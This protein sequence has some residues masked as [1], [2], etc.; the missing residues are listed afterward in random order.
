MHCYLQLV[1]VL[2]HRMNTQTQERQVWISTPTSGHIKV[3]QR[4]LD[5]I[6]LTYKYLT[7]SIL[8]TFIKHTIP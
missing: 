6:S 7:V 2:M 8:Q 1:N 4:L 3:R 5:Y